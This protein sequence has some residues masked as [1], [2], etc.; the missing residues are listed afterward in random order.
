MRI[1][2]VDLDSQRSEFNEPLGVEVLS[3][4][5]LSRFADKVEIVVQTSRLGFSNLLKKT[6]RIC[7]EVVAVSVKIGGMNQFRS[8]YQKLQC[9]SIPPKAIIVGGIIPTLAPEPFLEEFPNVICVKGEGEEA[10]S[11]IINCI[12]DH[13]SCGPEFLS[14]II[15]KSIPNIVFRCGDDYFITQR[16][17]IDLSN[18]RPLQRDTIKEVINRGGV[19]RAEASRGCPWGQCSFCCVSMKYGKSCW[20]PLPVHT[21]LE[22]IKNMSALGVGT[23]YFSD[24]D[25]IGNDRERAEYLVLSILEGKSK[26]R[27]HQHMRFFISTSVQSLFPTGVTANVSTKKFL[28]LLRRAGFEEVFLGIESGCDRQLKRY[29]KGADSETN[30]MA[31]RILQEEGFYVDIGFLMFDPEASLNDIRENIVFL[32][33]TGLINT[34]ARLIKEVR[35]VPSTPLAHSLSNRGLLG[36][37]NYDQLKYDFEYA[38][39]VVGQIARAFRHWHSNTLPY[40]DRL[41]SASRN[42]AADSYLRETI[43]IYLRKFRFL[44]ICLLR[45]FLLEA[46]DRR[47]CN[48]SDIFTRIMNREFCTFKQLMTESEF[49]LDIDSQGT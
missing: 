39:P 27:I 23:I 18:A 40:I 16:K 32:E 49:K 12:F 10:L 1:L 5:L 3:N 25:F 36:A 44:D 45:S 30:A 47:I 41:Q 29:C 20:R 26:S 2:I 46:N 38:D 48:F 21:I 6:E 35:V 14:Q 17:L 34:D 28:N 24:E 33:R 9:L 7:P 19:V 42:H 13:P 22:D 11:E 4:A 15:I 31:V 37:L 43:R 8:F